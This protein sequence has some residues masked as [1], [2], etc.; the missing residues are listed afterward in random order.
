[1]RPARPLVLLV[2][3]LGL[4]LGACGSDAGTGDAEPTTTTVEGCVQTVRGCIDPD[5]IEPGECVPSSSETDDCVNY[6]P[7]PDDG[8]TTSTTSG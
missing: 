6:R 7:L 5:S 1:M 8:E 3:V 4:V 2:G